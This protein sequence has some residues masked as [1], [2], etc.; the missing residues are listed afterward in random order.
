MVGLALREK[1]DQGRVS[2]ALIKCRTI[3]SAHRLTLLM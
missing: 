1:P 3:H 2:T